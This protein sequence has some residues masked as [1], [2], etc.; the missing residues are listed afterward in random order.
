M[1]KISR[2]NPLLEALKAPSNRIQKILI[3][4]NSSSKKIEAIIFQAKTRGISCSFV[5]RQELDKMDPHH[6][7][8]V[9][10]VA[11]KRMFSFDEILN[12][13]ILVL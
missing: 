7:G 10:F 5:S 4:K 1:G 12:A 13:H 3:Q 2:L 6:Q 11:E 8:L 9:A